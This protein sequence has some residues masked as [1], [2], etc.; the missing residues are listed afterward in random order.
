MRSEFCRRAK[1]ANQFGV[2]DV[3]RVGL[4]GDPEAGSSSRILDSR[5]STISFVCRTLKS[6]S[7]KALRRLFVMSRSSSSSRRRLDLRKP[8]DRKIPL[9]AFQRHVFASQGVGFN[10]L[11]VRKSGL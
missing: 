9:E 2:Q 8:R 3:H 5:R 11:T 6:A 7:C 1:Q 10:L 4:E